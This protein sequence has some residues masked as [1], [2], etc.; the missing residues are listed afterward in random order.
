VRAW[1]QYD[2]ADWAK[3]TPLVHGAKR[4]R[5]VAV[6]RAFRLLP[7]AGYDRLMARLAQLKPDV[8][9][10]AVAYN[11]PWVIDLHTEAAKRNVAGT[12]VVCDNSS[13]AAARREIEAICDARGVPYLPLPFNIEY[14]PCRS[15]GIALNWIYYNIIDR[16]RPRVFAF[17]DHDLFAIDRFDPSALIADQPVYGRINPSDWGWNL[18]A[19]YCMF[20]RAAVARFIPDFNN[21]NPRLLDTGGRN[22]TQIYR[23]LDRSR[24]RFAAEG[25]LQI[26]LADSVRPVTVQQIDNCLHVGG[27]SFED[28]AGTR[29]QEAAYRAIIRHLDGG[30]VL[31]DLTVDVH[32]A[33]AAS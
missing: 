25:M 23:H 21:D 10:L 17:L 5:N 29:R 7:A 2:G 20:D 12:L 15:H 4:A 13:R 18:W 9:V 28:D 33:V 30:G 19:G 22:W 6:D 16:L 11:T 32:E 14:H 3:A 26:R 24:L 27:A 1:N 8:L 31:S